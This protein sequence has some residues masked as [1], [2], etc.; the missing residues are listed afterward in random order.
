MLII[1]HCF[2]YGSFA[3]I[4]IRYL[5]LQAR[6]VKSAGTLKWRPIGCCMV[7]HRMR[8]ACGYVHGPHFGLPNRVRWPATSAGFVSGP[9]LTMDMLKRSIFKAGQDIYLNLSY[10]QVRHASPICALWDPRP[11]HYS[12]IKQDKKHRAYR[13]RCGYSLGSTRGILHS[14]DSSVKGSLLCFVYSWPL[15]SA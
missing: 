10:I 6:R 3:W 5:Q 11:T 13:A 4:Y 14:F 7:F 8:C 12:E 9:P 2:L 1:P 15:E